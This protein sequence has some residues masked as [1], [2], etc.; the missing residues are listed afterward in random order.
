MQ[1]E[2]TIRERLRQ[3]RREH[4]PATFDEID[5]EVGRQYAAVQAEVVAELSMAAAEQDTVP[6]PCPACAQPMQRRGTRRRS[7]TTRHG[8]QAKMERTY[9]AC[10]ACGTGLFPPG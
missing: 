5:A 4:P 3:W 2:A 7:V 1:Q 8:V 9:Y 6:P 10:P